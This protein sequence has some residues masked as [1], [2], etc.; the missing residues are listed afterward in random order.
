MNAKISNV[1]CVSKSGLLTCLNHMHHL[2]Y[3]NFRLRDSEAQ[4]KLK[5]LF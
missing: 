2:F 4:Q 1:G 5:T 3:T